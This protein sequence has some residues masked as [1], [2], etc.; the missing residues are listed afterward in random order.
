[1]TLEEKVKAFTD[2]NITDGTAYELQNKYVSLPF[3]SVRD[4]KICFLPKSTIRVMYGSNGMCAGNTPAEAIVQGI[5]EIFERVS[6]RRILFEKPNLPDVPDE[7]IQKYPDIYKMYKKLQ[8]IDGYYV[9]MKDC[10]FGGKYPVAGLLIVEKNT[11]HYGIKLGCHPDFGIA[12]ERTF[13]EATQGGDIDDYASRS[14]IDFSNANVTSLYNISNSFTVGFA[15]YPYEILKSESN[16]FVPVPDV[17]NLSNKEI[18]DKWTETIINEG[19]DI[20]I[21]DV[22]TLGF[23]SFHVIIPGLTEMDA[24]DSMMRARNTRAYV[25]KALIKPSKLDISDIKYILGV[26]GY[27]DKY[28]T[29]NA[30]TGLFPYYEGDLPFNI[31][32]CGL[33]YLAAMCYAT[34]GDYLKASLSIHTIEK[35]FANFNETGDNMNYIS[36]LKYYFQAMQYIKDHSKVINY[37]KCLFDYDLC[38][39]ID[40]LFN[41]NKAI[42]SKQ[43]KDSNSEN[44]AFESAT[45]IMTEVMNKMRRKQNLNKIDQINVTVNP[46][47]PD[48]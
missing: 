15:Q 33:R 12:M 45:Y 21:R 4:D 28:I 11:G 23:P 24:G 32:N 13:T 29:Q 2:V 8:A 14:T 46:T 19:Y 38:D 16:K 22:S 6:Q 20:L 31:H 37:L 34:I 10:S 35:I 3:Y 5:S 27:Y 39:K 44:P 36:A 41:D 7:Y 47:Q 40:N 43:Y 25:T 48:K 1:M 42:L 30:I 17:S 18:L 26:I 9:T